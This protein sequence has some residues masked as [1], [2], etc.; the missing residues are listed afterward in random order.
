MLT[1]LQQNINKDW[2]PL[3]TGI[4][5]RYQQYSF[6]NFI[7]R[8]DKYKEAKLCC[9]E[10]FNY[11][12]HK[13]G[14]FIGG[15]PG[16][17]K[18]HLA[19]GTIRNLEIITENGIPRKAKAKMIDADEYFNLLYNAINSKQSKD[20]V[21]QELYRYNDVLLLD[22]LG[23][24]NMTM[25]KQENLYLLINYTY[26]HL[27]KIIITTNFTLDEFAKYDER[28]S[29]RLYEMCHIIVL[30]GEDYRLKQ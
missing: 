15:P 17:G 23:L 25:A 21:I 5:K 14:L 12:S 8:G 29:S 28:I 19:V 18:T 1:L 7:E 6:N 2:I 30:T 20:K 22:D 27:S 11:K 24:I 3:I 9:K 10:Y 13:S 16:V 26:M 4:P